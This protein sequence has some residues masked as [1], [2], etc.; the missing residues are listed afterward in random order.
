MDAPESFWAWLAGFIDGDGTI[1]LGLCFRRTRSH[2]MNIHVNAYFSVCQHKKAKQALEEIHQTI[3]SGYLAGKNRTEAA[4]AY[5]TLRSSMWRYTLNER[6]VLKHALGK[7]VPYLRIKQGQARTLLCALEILEKAMSRKILFRNGE[8]RLTKEEAHELAAMSVGINEEAQNTHRQSWDELKAKIET[9]YAQ[10][11]N[12]PS[13]PDIKVPCSE[14]GT[15][16]VRAKK[17]VRGAVFCKPECRVSFGKKKAEARKLDVVCLNCQKPMR[18]RKSAVSSMNFCTVTCCAD[19]N[20]KN[21][22]VFKSWNEP[23]NSF[24]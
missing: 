15:E 19:W 4:E 11:E 12:E 17:R 5:G 13:N 1:V 21:R 20:R 6:G 10:E 14:C 7:L 24:H 9:V 16:V 3:G 2:R 22:H 8:R 18:R 23:P